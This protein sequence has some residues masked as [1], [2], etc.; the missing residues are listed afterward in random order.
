MN[1]SEADALFRAGNQKIR[2]LAKR[3][4]YTK[5]RW[6]GKGGAHPGRIYRISRRVN[7]GIYMMWDA[8]GYM[9]PPGMSFKISVMDLVKGYDLVE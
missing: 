3:K 7:D 8:I 4:D 6:R 1:K 2:K 5:A 9:P